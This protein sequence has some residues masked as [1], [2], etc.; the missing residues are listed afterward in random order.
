MKKEGKKTQWA[1]RT[2]EPSLDMF[3]DAHITN[4]RILYRIT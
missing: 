3:C 1:R 2:M 4:S